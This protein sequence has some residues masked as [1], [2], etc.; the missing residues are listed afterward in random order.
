MRLMGVDLA[1]KSRD[2]GHGSSGICCL[3]AGGRV[4]ELELVTCDDEILERVRSQEEIWVGIDAP[5]RVTNQQGL[6][7]CERQLMARGIPC[8]PSNREYMARRYGGMRGESLARS[9]VSEGFAESPS[10]PMVGRAVFETY[11]YGTLRLLSARVL[12][13]KRGRFEV[14]RKAMLEAIEVLE[15][16]DAPGP[17]VDR[18][19]QEADGAR[20]STIKGM[21]DLLDAALCATC[22]YSHWIS[23]GRRTQLVGEEEHG[24]I[25][26]P[27]ERDDDERRAD[28]GEGLPGGRKA[29]RIQRG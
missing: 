27:A 7:A 8:L 16:W 24:Y 6:R 15:A 26:L 13:Y 3:E 4:V 20:A 18:L 22:V 12:R 11:P 14:R 2:P 1:W 21:G 10:S 29:I 5:L 23:G 28:H 25:L 9:L 19:R 17:L